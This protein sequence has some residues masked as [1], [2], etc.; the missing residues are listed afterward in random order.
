MLRTALIVA[1]LAWGAYFLIRYVTNEQRHRRQARDWG[2]QSPPREQ[3]T[4]YGV[5]LIK[6][7]IQAL[8]EERA[9]KYFIEWQERNWPTYVTRFF[10][11]EVIQ[12][13]EPTNIQAM[14]ATQFED[15][16]LGYRLQSWSPL[17]GRGIFTTDGAEWFV[18]P[19]AK[20]YW[21]TN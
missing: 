15:F 2:C 9:T 10:D 6:E 5:V 18:H 19:A 20:F 12:T 11:T 4:W 8:R 1:G 21:A 17:L 14:L 16:N 3:G 7:F 13:C